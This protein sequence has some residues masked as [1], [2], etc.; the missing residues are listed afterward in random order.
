[1][2]VHRTPPSCPFCKKDCYKAIY[3]ER[4]PLLHDTFIGD[5]FLYW[6]YIPHK[7]VEPQIFKWGVLEF[8]LTVK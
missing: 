3:K 1:M 2:A 4:E 7:C 6:E 5:D 8:N